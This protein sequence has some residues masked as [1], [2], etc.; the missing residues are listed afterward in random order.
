MKWAMVFYGNEFESKC[1]GEV[2]LRSVIRGLSLAEKLPLLFR[3]EKVRVERKQ[4][5]L[6]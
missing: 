6:P 3:F 1:W 2:S 4:I 5:D